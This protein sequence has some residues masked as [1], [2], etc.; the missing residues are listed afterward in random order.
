MKQC[1]PVL[2][3]LYS[4][5]D[6]INSVLPWGDPLADGLG[7]PVVTGVVVGQRVQ[8]KHLK[9]RLILL[10]C[11]DINRNSTGVYII[12]FNHFPLPPNGRSFFPPTILGHGGRA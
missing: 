3:L 9:K 1:R 12:H 6:D 4:I 7:L 5:S 10:K 2:A 8:D 11:I